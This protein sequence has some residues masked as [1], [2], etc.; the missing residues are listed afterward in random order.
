MVL[1]HFV[2]NHYA[3]LTDAQMQTL[4]ELLGQP[5]NDLWDLVTARAESL[6]ATQREMLG[7]MRA[8][9]VKNDKIVVTT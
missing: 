4:D 1:Q 2:N 3:G 5:D 8:C 9:S 6:H 7:L